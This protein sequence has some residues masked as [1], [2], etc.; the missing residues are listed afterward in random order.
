MPIQSTLSPSRGREARTPVY[1]FGD[2]RTTTVLFPCVC[3]ITD[4]S[5]YNTEQGKS[6]RDIF[7]F[8]Y[9][10]IFNSQPQKI[11]SKHPVNDLLHRLYSDYLN[12]TVLPAVFRTYIGYHTGLEAKFFRLRH[13]LPGLAHRT[14]LTA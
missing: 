4:E 6:A 3:V 7:I 11:S 12:T 10:S 2:R 5:H 8:I 13:P 1:G 14:N 9:L